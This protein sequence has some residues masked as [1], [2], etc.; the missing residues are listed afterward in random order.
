MSRS[1][2]ASTPPSGTKV[3]AGSEDRVSF[4]RQ[5]RAVPCQLAAPLTAPRTYA[6]ARC[7]RTSA[8]RSHTRTHAHKPTKGVCVSVQC[9]G[10]CCK[11]PSSQTQ[12]DVTFHT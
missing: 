6:M 5:T 4:V 8:V 9:N 11:F 10:V 3:G 7:V 2:P 12:D 1:V